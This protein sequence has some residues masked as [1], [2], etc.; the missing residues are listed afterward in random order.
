MK[1]FLI[2]LLSL[3]S[4]AVLLPAILAVMINVYYWVDEKLSD[5]L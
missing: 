2:I 4:F 5:I 3:V 1:I